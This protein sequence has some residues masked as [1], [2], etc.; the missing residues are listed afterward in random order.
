MSMDNG[1][2]C[3]FETI[4]VH[5]FTLKISLSERK[6]E[7]RLTLRCLLIMNVPSEHHIN[8]HMPVFSLVGSDSIQLVTEYYIFLLLV[9]PSTN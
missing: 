8:N 2:D 5:F 1:I 4:V 7:H 3:T 6:K 9:P